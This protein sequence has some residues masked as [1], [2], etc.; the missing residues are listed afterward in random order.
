MMNNYY[1]SFRV[2]QTSLHKKKQENRNLPNT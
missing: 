1:D 2:K